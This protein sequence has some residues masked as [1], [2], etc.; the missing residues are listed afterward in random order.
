[1]L[2]LSFFSPFFVKSVMKWKKKKILFQFKKYVIN[3]YISISLIT[4]FPIPTPNPIWCV[5]KKRLSALCEQ[6]FDKRKLKQCVRYVPV[7]PWEWKLKKIWR[8]DW[9]RKIL[10]VFRPLQK[11]IFNIFYVIKRLYVLWRINLV[12]VSRNCIIH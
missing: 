9:K 7:V 4:S 11:K 3:L 2:L 10:P 5:R 6:K 12:A 1:M 8:C